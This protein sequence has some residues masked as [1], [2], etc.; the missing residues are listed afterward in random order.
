MAP[1]A[2]SIGAGSATEGPGVD[3][4]RVKVLAVTPDL[5]APPV[6]ARP[7]SVRRL[8]PTD[9]DRQVR[10]QPTGR[11]WLVRWKTR[12]RRRG[13]GPARACG[14][15]RAPARGTLTSGR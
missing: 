2:V 12:V 13:R 7:S 6:Y 9:F 1:L 11:R 3:V 10:A 5:A 14:V 15:D 8:A 4:A